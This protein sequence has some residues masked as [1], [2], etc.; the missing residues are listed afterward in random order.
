MV[1]GLCALQQNSTALRTEPPDE[2]PI[3]PLSERA[4]P[5]LGHRPRAPEKGEPCL[6]RPGLLASPRS[7]APWVW[8]RL[9]C[10]DKERNDLTVRGIRG[11]GPHI[12]LREL[13]L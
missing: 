12:K 5:L 4:L 7:E 6:G 10:V 9:E 8:Y 2:P 1:G 3:E 13:V 11:T